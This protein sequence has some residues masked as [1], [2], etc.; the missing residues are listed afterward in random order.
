MECAAQN[1]SALAIFSKNLASMLLQNYSKQIYPDLTVYDRGLQTM[2]REGIS[3]GRK[4][5]LSIMKKWNI[6]KKLVD[7]VAC[8][9]ISKQSHSARCPVFELLCNNT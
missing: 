3:S 9:H 2:A 8:K 7:F 1:E 4:D 5:I 6:Y